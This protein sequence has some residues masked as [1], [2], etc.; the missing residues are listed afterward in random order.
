MR[1]GH[2]RASNHDSCLLMGIGLSAA[3]TSCCRAE[4]RRDTKPFPGS[5]SSFCSDT[6]ILNLLRIRLLASLQIDTLELTTPA[7]KQVVPR[8]FHL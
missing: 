4:G 1:L 6:S 7:L 5:T 8:W 2:T 3:A